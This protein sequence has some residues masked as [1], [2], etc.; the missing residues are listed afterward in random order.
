MKREKNLYYLKDSTVTGA[1][2]AVDD[3]DEDATRLWHMIGHAGENLCNYWL[4]RAY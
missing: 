4:G 1:L 3:S 2:V